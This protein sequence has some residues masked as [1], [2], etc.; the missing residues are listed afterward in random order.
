MWAIY[1]ITDEHGRLK[2]GI[3]VDVWRRLQIGSADLLTLACFFVI[4][5]WKVARAL[6]TAVHERLGK[7]KVR[8]EWF[9]V[10]VRTAARVIRQV[11]AEM[12]VA[13]AKVPVVSPRLA[14]PA[15]TVI[16]AKPRRRRAA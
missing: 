6:E 8:G 9:R 5:P 2:I 15:K 1:I 13:V 3:A 11:A 14:K 10:S 16:P 7:H 4:G 12:G